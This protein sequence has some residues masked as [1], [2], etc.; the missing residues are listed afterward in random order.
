MEPVD[1]QFPLGS[2]DSQSHSAG[3]LAALGGGAV[4]VGGLYVYILSS[5]SYEDPV[6]LL[7]CIYIYLCSGL[8]LLYWWFRVEGLDFF[9]LKIL[10]ILYP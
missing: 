7:P 9:C 5:L 3:Y 6:L 2:E 8:M 4:G 1:F 10:L